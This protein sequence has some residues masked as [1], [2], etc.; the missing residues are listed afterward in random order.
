[1]ITW[2]IEL[3]DNHIA[4]LQWMRDTDDMATKD[5]YAT[6]N[7]PRITHWITGV[8]G[9]ERMGLAQHFDRGQN[10]KDKQGAYITARGRAILAIVEDDLASFAQKTRR[11][12]RKRE[13]A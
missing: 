9:L 13:A 7:R 1:M 11:K 6:D 8:R 3:T 12:T 5:R 10:S 2:K 4:L